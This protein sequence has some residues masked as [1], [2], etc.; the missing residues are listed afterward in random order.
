MPIPY[1][2]VPPSTSGPL[3]AYLLS[4]AGKTPKELLGGLLVIDGRG[5]PVEFVH[6]C[7][8]VPSGL[9][10]PAP[11]VEAAGFAALAHSLF[12][13]CRAQPDLLVIEH[14][15]GT[16][17]YIREKVAPLIPTCIVSQSQEDNP[18]TYAWV[19]EAPAIGT[20]AHLLIEELAERGFL[21][22]PFDRIRRALA[23]TYGTNEPGT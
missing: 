21:H 3:A 14:G 23:E 1:H 12:E 2:R 22:E 6:N 19:N 18:S 10:W 7:I 8:E 11:G 20:S 17:H 5:Q 9:L 4:T 16:P 13:A 15:L